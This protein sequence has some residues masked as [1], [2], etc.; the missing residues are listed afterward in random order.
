MNKYGTECVFCEYVDLLEGICTLTKQYVRIGDDTC[1]KFKLGRDLRDNDRQERV[2]T[3][4]AK[5][6]AWCKM[7][8]KTG[9]A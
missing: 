6:A 3:D 7:C 2:A 1:R 5:L 4:K 9:K 8:G